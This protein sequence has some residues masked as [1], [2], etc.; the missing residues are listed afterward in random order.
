MPDFPDTRYSLIE[1]VQDLADEAA[2]VEF[3][4]IYQPVL[5]RMARRR[6]LQDA[7]AQDVIQHFLFHDSGEHH[8]TPFASNRLTL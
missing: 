2:W 1:R 8:G 3:L 5:Y 4:A 7:D 6:G